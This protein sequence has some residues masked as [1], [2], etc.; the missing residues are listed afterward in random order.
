MTERTRVRQQPSE[1]VLTE[2]VTTAGYA[3]SVHNTQPWRW[4]VLPDCVELLAERG[5]QLTAADPEARLLTLSCGTALHHAT[6]TTQALGWECRVDRMPDPGRPDLLAVLRP[7]GRVAVTEQATRLWR[8]T[9]VRHTDRRPVGDEP[10]PEADL[11]AVT[12]AVTD[13]ARLHLLTRDQVMDLA[14]AASQAG[15]VEYADPTVR[16]ELAY[17]TGRERP[18][19]AGLPAEVLP[20][21]PARTTVPHRDFGRPGTLAVGGGHDRGASYALLYGDDDEPGSWLRA[22]EAL[23]AA[24]LTAVD[25]GVSVVPLSA[26]VEVEATRQSL[27]RV[28]AALGWPYLVLRLGTVRPELGPPPRTPRIPVTQVVERP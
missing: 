13:R 8:A 11:R 16:E 25:L 7:V 17:W 18:A 28:L 2:A 24:W 6:V 26:V 27:R 9:R 10:L 20:D 22:G 4:R 5:R 1:E 23:S 3:P 19:G 12:R 21:R 14:A 15:T